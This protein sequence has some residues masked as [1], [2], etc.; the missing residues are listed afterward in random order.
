MTRMG[1]GG[2]VKSIIGSMLARVWSHVAGDTLISGSIITVTV[3][4]PVRPEPEISRIAQA[5]AFPRFLIHH[6]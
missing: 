3:P 6:L 4:L 5:W 1:P 2:M